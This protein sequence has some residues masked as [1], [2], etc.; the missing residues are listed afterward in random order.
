MITVKYNILEFKYFA[1]KNEI[2]T[3]KINK[4]IFLKFVSIFLFF[5]QSKFW[6]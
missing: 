1:I 6:T 5:I 3:D 4:I 2:N